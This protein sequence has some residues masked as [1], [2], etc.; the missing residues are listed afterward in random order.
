MMGLFDKLFGAKDGKTAKEWFELGFSAKDPEK[1]LEYYT[2]ALEINPK[3]V[4]AW[5]NK[6]DTLRDLRK[7]EEAM[8]CFDKALEVNPSQEQTKRN[9]EIAREKMKHIKAK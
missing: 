8:V 6:G 2:K 4:E 7:Y 5:F 3:F 1:Q 9:R